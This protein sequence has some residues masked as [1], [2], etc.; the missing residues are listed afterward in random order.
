MNPIARI[1]KEVENMT[2][3]IMKS[4]ND[5]SFYVMLFHVKIGTKKLKGE[6]LN[7]NQ[8]L[9]ESIQAAIQECEQLLDAFLDDRNSDD[10]YI[11]IFKEKEKVVV[12]LIEDLK[13]KTNFF[14]NKTIYADEILEDL[15][16][17]TISFIETAD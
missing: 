15:E 5:L 14:W 8:E 12:G 13:K 6:D 10:N 9:I 17:A 2:K 4:E 3:F 11:K 1:A 7:F 16:K